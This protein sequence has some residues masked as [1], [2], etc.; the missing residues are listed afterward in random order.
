ML[1]VGIHANQML[2]FYHLKVGYIVQFDLLIGV[3]RCRGPATYSAKG[4][5]FISLHYVLDY[6]LNCV[7]L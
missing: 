7:H 5:Q 2:P 4:L 6:D 3:F 1:T